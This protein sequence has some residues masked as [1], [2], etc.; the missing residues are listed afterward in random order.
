MPV[1]D[2]EIN[3]RFALYHADCMEVLPDL[4]AESVGLSL[5]SPPFPELYQ[6]SDDPRDMCNCVSYQESLEQYRYVVREVVR[7]TRP[8]RLSC[9]HSTD[10]KRGILYQHD[11]PGDIIRIHEVEGMH[12]FCRVTI[13]KDAWEFARRTRMKTLMHKTIVED[14]CSS[15]LAPG[16]YLLV[17][18]KPGQ[19]PEP[20]THAQGFKGYAGERHIPPELARQFENYAGEQKKNA[21]SQWIYRQYASPVWMD[22]RRER[23]LP[24]QDS[25]ENQEERHVCPLQLD[26]IDRCL[27]L[28]SNP[29]DT[30]LTPF[31]GVGSEA[32]GAIVNDRRAIGIELKASYYRQACRNIQAALKIWADNIVAKTPLF[33]EAPL[34]EAP[35]AL[36]RIMEED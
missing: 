20:I 28:W 30:V 26:V 13:W 27:A 31:M 8:G 11:F 4:P 10:L 15:R 36:D 33:K 9:V 24:Y 32:Y 19:N 22:I 29:G 16:D 3:D 18:K 35:E 5:Y 34:K 25:K 6:Y 14:S 23:L 17:F 7:L 2:Q 1:R 12:Y 21:L